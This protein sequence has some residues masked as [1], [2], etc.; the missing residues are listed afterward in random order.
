M[1]IAGCSQLTDVLH[2]P[3]PAG[4]EPASTLKSRSG[5]E[6]I[7]T[8][9]KASV[10]QAISGTYGAI[11]MSGMLTDE[12]TFGYFVYSGSYA[13]IDARRTAQFGNFSEQSDFAINALLQSRSQLLLAEA[14]LQQFE[15]AS[16]QWR[17]GEAYALVGYTELFLA[18]EYCA[19]VPLSRARVD[20]GW[21]YGTPLTTDSLLAVAE[22]HFDSAL[23]YAGENVTVEG[24][25]RVGLGRARLDRGHFAE[26]SAAVTSVPTAFAYSAEMSPDANINNVNLYQE[27]VSNC[28]S[29]TMSDREG[30][31]GLDF[32]TAHDPRLVTDTTVGQTCDRA[33]GGDMSSVY[34]YPV[35]F[36]TPSSFVPFSTG[37][38]ARLIEAEAA[39]HGNDATWIDQLNALRTSC[40]SAAACDAPAPP[41]SGSVAGLPPLDDPVNPDARVDLLFR[42]RAFWLFGTGTRLGDLR[43]LV[44]QYTRSAETVFPTGPYA[45]GDNPG[46]PEPLTTYG[47]DVSLTLPTGIYGQTGNPSYRGCISP[48]STP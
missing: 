19:G 44:R 6:S 5:A 1:T 8:A 33:Y 30:G 18:E 10:F 38:E 41:G 32:I 27:G 16:E 45:H 42:E 7:F 22:A 17:A 12:L 20:G 40:T 37:I 9:A 4:I 28:S 43:R 15:P 47:T 3:A 13:N 46:L 39:L 23:A 34:Y 2:A 24:L 26:A 31:N 48:T 21:E 11:W 29:F 36:G 35:K 25:A 14:G